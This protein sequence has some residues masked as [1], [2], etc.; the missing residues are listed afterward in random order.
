MAQKER[1]ERVVKKVEDLVGFK[2]DTFSPAKVLELKD[3]LEKLAHLCSLNE[4][5]CGEL[6]EKIETLTHLCSPNEQRD[7]VLFML[8]D[9]SQ[10]QT[11]NLVSTVQ[12]VLKEKT[13]KIGVLGVKPFMWGKI[14]PITLYTVKGVKEFG[15]AKKLIAE[16]ERIG[17]TEKGKVIE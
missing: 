17:L 14:A 16:L 4:R 10:V 13:P 12:E 5:R 7:E 8:V 2:I 6:E 3:K 9:P 15:E 11:T 1:K